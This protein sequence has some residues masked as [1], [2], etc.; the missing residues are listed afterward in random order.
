MFDKIKQIVAC[1]TLL[2]YPY[3]NKRFDKHTDASDFQLGA[4]VIHDGKLIAFHSCRLIGPQTRYKETENELLSIVKTLKEF[5]TILS[6]QQLKI[7]NNYKNI[8]CK[9][10]NT[11]RV[12]QCILVLEEY[13][14]DIDYIPVEKNIA[15]D[16]L[17]QLP[18]N[19]NQENTHGTTYTTETMS[20]LYGI[21]EL[22]HDTFTIYFK[23]IDRYQREDHILIEKVTCT[24]Y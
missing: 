20:E 8:S 7:Y 16:A 5:R 1:N 19:K 14:P 13:G 12:L 6:G 22:P 3:S 21:E 2:I 4:V 18:N 10:F 23:L 17:S 24:E 11:D 9:N 15:I